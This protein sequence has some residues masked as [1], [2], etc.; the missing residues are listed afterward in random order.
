MRLIDAYRSL[1]SQWSLLFA[2]GAANLRRGHRPEP[3]LAFLARW[4]RERRL[5]RRYPLTC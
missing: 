4:Q 1:F 3:L 5:V 2:V